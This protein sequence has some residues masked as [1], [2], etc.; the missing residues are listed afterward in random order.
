MRSKF[1]MSTGACQR[2]YTAGNL[3]QLGQITRLDVNCAYPRA[4][5]NSELDLSASEH[6]RKMEIGLLQIT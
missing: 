2:T 1:C 5:G 3:V 6:S 4:T